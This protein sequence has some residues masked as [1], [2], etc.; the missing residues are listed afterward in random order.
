MTI[1]RAKKTIEMA[2]A[3]H[4]AY[5]RL[6]PSF[7][8]MTREDTREFDPASSNGRLMTAVCAEVAALVRAQVIEEAA[9]VCEALAADSRQHPLCQAMGEACA[10]RI[11]E[12]DSGHSTARAGEASTTPAKEPR[13][14]KG[15]VNTLA[16]SL[17]DLAALSRSIQEITEKYGLETSPPGWIPVSERL[18]EPKQPVLVAA[19][20]DGPGDW[21]IKV[22]GYAPDYPGA[23]HGWHIHGASWR[24]THWMPLPPAPKEA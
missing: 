19:E 17:E 3:F 24:P 11:R 14:T 5:E 12:P 7:G 10:A 20:F 16:A 22:G 23:F 6:A 13:V 1:D 8:Y 15:M 2:R 21:R 9:K 18:P 4:E